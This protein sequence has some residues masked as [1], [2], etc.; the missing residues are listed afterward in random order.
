MYIFLQP[1]YLK[2]DWA[3]GP[4]VGE[5]CVLVE[6]KGELMSIDKDTHNDILFY[7]KANII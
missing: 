7:K 5:F 2:G 3:L 4:Q 1:N 6:E